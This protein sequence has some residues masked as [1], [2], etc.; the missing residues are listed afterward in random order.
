[1]RNPESS[2]VKEV[3]Y[4][5]IYL[6]SIGNFPSCSFSFIIFFA[7][8]QVLGKGDKDSTEGIVQERYGLDPSEPNVTF[9]LCCGTHSSPAVRNPNFRP[10]NILLHNGN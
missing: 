7:I 4:I 8:F 5:Y 10:E 1:M 9:A 3:I 2:L 6:A